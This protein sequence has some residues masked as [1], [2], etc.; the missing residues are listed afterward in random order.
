M[1]FLS[2]TTDPLQWTPLSTQT[3]MDHTQSSQTIKLRH[4]H[5]LSQVLVQLD[6]AAMLPK[7]GAI[8]PEL[9]RR[10][11]VHA[12][13]VTRLLP[14]VR[15]RLRRKSHIMACPSAE[16]KQHTRRPDNRTHPGPPPSPPERAGTCN[17]TRCH[18]CHANRRHVYWH[19]ETQQ[20]FRSPWPLTYL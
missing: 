4:Q 19:E 10:Q 17:H 9:Q 18:L 16:Q 3:L 7:L 2:S 12:Q 15:V 1:S 11:H 8:A 14:L 20:R 13:P 5:T 6:D